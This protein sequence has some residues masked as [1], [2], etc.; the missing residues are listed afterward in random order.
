MD[1]GAR[2]VRL[3][4]GSLVV[5]RPVHPTDVPLLVDGFAR[6]S[7]QSRRQRFLTAKTEL[8]PDELRRLTEL[9]HHDREALGAVDVRTGQ[10]VGIARYVRPAD[11]PQTA[12]VAVTVVDEWHRR[13]VATALLHRLALRARDAGIFAFTALVS[14][15]NDAMTGLL[16]T[17][18]GVELTHLDADVAEY[19]IALVPMLCGLRCRA[20]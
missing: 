14:V 17:V 3:R 12:E 15:D 7:P 16:R 2:T 19:E 18:A 8:T 4:D 6:L 1:D 11:E 5:V 13:G 9:D 10:G 20:A